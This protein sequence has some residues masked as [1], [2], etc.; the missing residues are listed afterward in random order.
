MLLVS[1]CTV[2]TSALSVRHNSSP[3]K[4]EHSRKPFSRT[5]MQSAFIA[6]LSLVTFSLS[7]ETVTLAFSIIVSIVRYDVS[8]TNFIL[9]TSSVPLPLTETFEKPLGLT[10]SSSA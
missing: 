9:F 6:S 8:G 10:V 2:L 7:S 4:K 3:L 5:E 1:Q